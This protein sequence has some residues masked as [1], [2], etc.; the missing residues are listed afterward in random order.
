MSLLLYFSKVF[1]LSGLLYGY[2]WLVLRNA[3]FHHYNRAY[4]LAITLLSFV[5]PFLSVPEGWNWGSA[6]QQGKGGIMHVILPGNWEEPVVLTGHRGGPALWMYWEWLAWGLYFAV[7]AVFLFLLLRS[8]FYIRRLS[9]RYPR[10]QMEGIRFFITDEPGTPFSFFRSIFWNSRLDIDS[11]N[12]SQVFRHE[13]YHIRERHT[14]DILLLQSVRIVCWFNPFFHLIYR[15]IKALHEFLADQHVLAG[16]DKY[17]YAELLVWQTIRNGQAPI[18]H[19]FFHTHIKRRITMITRFKEKGPGYFSRIMAL[20]LL[21]IL[22]CAFATGLRKRTSSSSLPAGKAITVVIDAGHGGFDNGAV[23]KSGIAEKDAV[24]AIAKKIK[25]FS[26]DY[27]VNIIMTRDDDR[28]PGNKDNIHDGL[29]YRADL[30]KENRA[31]LYIS[32]HM[33]AEGKEAVHGFDIYIARGNS[34]YKQSAQ[35]GSAMLESLKGSYQTD[36]MLREREENIYVLRNTAMPSIL[37]TCGDLNVDKDWEFFSKPAN[38]DLVAKDILQGIVRY[39]KEYAGSPSALASPAGTDTVPRVPGKEKKNPEGI[40]EAEYPGG[41][42]GWLN[43]LNTNFKYPRE[44]ADK[45]IQGTARVQFKVD[46]HGMT[47]DFTL[48]EDPG[49]ILGTE[50]LRVLKS[51]GKWL[52]ATLKGHPVA[53]YKI[54]PIVFK[55]VP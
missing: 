20:P 2:Y 42:E 30:A 49:S 4:L 32:L 44:A 53:S 23:S 3:P 21:F 25:Q 51:S 34:Q 22:F 40:E 6:P 19:P 46:E 37:I 1:L 45:N 54:Q 36:N 13:L 11:T 24:L 9:S 33:N 12:G 29:V 39:Q 50:A 48:L 7:A 38:Q 52:P 5:V 10:Q 47:R 27:P 55:L 17:E 35:L 41:Q 15:E 18:A 14:L 28:M 16:S 43:Y 8:L 31:D 26:A